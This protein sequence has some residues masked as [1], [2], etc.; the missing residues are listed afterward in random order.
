MEP[1]EQIELIDPAARPDRRA[2]GE[3]RQISLERGFN[4][5]AEGSAIVRWGDN[6]VYCTASLEEKVP[7]FL[8]G[9]G[10]GW[11]SAE[12]AM[13]P[14]STRERKQRDIRRGHL[15]GRSSEIQRLIGRSMRA[16]VDLAAM[17]ERTIWIDCDV[18]QADGG[19]RSASITGAFVCLVDALRRIWKE[20]DEL[21]LLAQVAAVSAGKRNGKIILDLCYEEDS[22]ADVDCNVVKTSSGKFV[23][24][25]GTGEG[26]FFSTEELSEIVS[27]ADEGL[28]RL[29]RMQRDVLELT[30]S[31]KALFDALAAGERLG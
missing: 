19:T 25:Q 3:L 31:E 5:Y 6:V 18:V 12:Y 24:F 7:S 4:R 9:S 26:G 11:V 13:L 14:R 28:A 29:Y 15:D 30:R 27:L 16:A 21:P 8:R 23:E 20:T 2:P 1:A 22:S 10:R 17:G